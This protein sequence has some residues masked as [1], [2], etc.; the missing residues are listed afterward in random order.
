MWKSFSTYSQ[1]STIHSMNYIGKRNLHWI[2]RWW[3]LFYHMSRVLTQLLSESSGCWLFCSRSRPAR[4]WFSKLMRSGT[5][6]RCWW[7][8]M[9]GQLLPGRWT[10]FWHSISSTKCFRL[11]SFSGCDHLPRVKNGHRQV[12]PDTNHRVEQQKRV[13]IARSRNRSRSAL[14]DLRFWWIHPEKS[15]KGER[16]LHRKASWREHWLCQQ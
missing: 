2:E 4:F 10:W 9:S 16:K 1:E 7:L 14:A 13:A 11:D 15:I 3:N 8:S 6:T 12:Q 5:K